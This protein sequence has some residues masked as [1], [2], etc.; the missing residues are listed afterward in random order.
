MPSFGA[1]R[2]VLFETTVFSP[3]EKTK[4]LYNGLLDFKPSNVLWSMV[5]LLYPPE[6]LTPMKPL[7]ASKEQFWIVTLLAW[8]LTDVPRKSM[9]L[10]ETP[11]FVITTM[12]RELL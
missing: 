6:L 11:S 5:K 10:S 3:R 12:L 4:S 7:D 8:I 2:K 1:S 9:P